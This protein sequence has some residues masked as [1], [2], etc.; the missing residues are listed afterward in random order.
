MPSHGTIVTLASD[1][2]VLGAALSIVGV[3]LRYL[4]LQDAKYIP[5]PIKNIIRGIRSGT[6]ESG[7]PV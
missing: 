1:I 5:I 2:V 3:V 6:E 4:L 7:D